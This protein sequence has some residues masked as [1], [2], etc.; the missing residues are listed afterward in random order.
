MKNLNILITGGMGLLGYSMIK[1]FSEKNYIK[2]IISIDSR[3]IEFLK[4]TNRKVKYI[5]TD[6]N[7]KLKIE[8]IIRKNEMN[9][10]FHTAAVTQVLEGFINLSKSSARSSESVIPFAVQLA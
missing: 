4:I 10:I 8:Q 1:Y 9:V 5:K 6:I 3:E 7:N 2:K